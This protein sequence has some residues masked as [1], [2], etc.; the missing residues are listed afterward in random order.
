MKPLTDSSPRP[1]S[2]RFPL[3]VS[4]FPRSLLPHSPGASFQLGSQHRLTQRPSCP[5]R[6]FPGNPITQVLS[7]RQGLLVSLNS[8]IYLVLLKHKLSAP[9]LTLAGRL[10]TKRWA[11]LPTHVQVFLQ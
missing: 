10:G 6:P 5:W 9:N 7:V 2:R 1:C 8:I 4:R 3:R 11:F